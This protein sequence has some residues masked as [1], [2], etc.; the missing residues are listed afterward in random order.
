MRTRIYNAR[1]LTMEEN[2]K[3]FTGEIRIEDGRIID[4]RSD[5]KNEEKDVSEARGWDEE[6]DACGNLIMPGFKDAHTHSP[7]TFLRSYADIP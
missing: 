6:I 1:I 7:M 3:I 4:V 2:R 5:G